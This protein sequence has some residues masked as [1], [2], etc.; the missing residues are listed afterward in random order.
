MPVVTPVTAATLAPRKDDTSAASLLLATALRSP[1]DSADAKDGATMLADRSSAEA[2]EVVTIVKSMDGPL[3]CKRRDAA[4][5][6]IRAPAAVRMAVMVMLAALT[7]KVAAIVA[8]STSRAAAEDARAF[9]S[10]LPGVNCRVAFVTATAV[11]GMAD[12]A[13]EGTAALLMM[14]LHAAVAQHVALENTATVAASP[15]A[16]REHVVRLTTAYVQTMPVALAH[17]P[18]MTSAALHARR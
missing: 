10:T 6:V 2:E 18:V 3:L 13:G 15:R 12:G 4:E 16:A 14:V 11:A 1:T 9:T 17:A 7:P 8:R 5:M